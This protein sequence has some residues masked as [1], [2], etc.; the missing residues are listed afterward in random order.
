VSDVIRVTR[1]ELFKLRKRP[2]TWVLLGTAVLLNL[3]F[4][5]LVPYLSYRSGGSDMLA[6]TSPAQ[7]LAS[8]LPD[9]LVTNT[10]GAFAVFS[11]A[12][13]LVLG[14]LIFGSEYG[15]GTVKTLLSQGPGRLVVVIGQLVALGIALLVG[16]LTMFVAGAVAATA[17]GVGESQQLVWPTPGALL[18]GV[19]AG[20]LILLMWSVLGAVLA[21]VLKGVA[22]PIGLGVVWV[23]GVESLV[24]AVAGSVLSAVQPLRDVLPGVNAG[25]FLAMVLPS[26]SVDPPPG[27]NTYVDG[28]RA[29]LTLVA[30]VLVCAVGSVL[31]VRR[32]DIT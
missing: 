4:G 12:L 3:S 19:M 22:L 20:W 6:G 25:S 28:D 30:Y 5:Y 9:Q 17:I 7:L 27:V 23:L 14:A 24:A 18:E 1:A 26:G 16:I 31:A 10:I 13:A 15:V 2:A 29:G 11:G 32:R 8:T 21:T